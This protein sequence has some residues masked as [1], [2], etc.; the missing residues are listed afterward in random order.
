MECENEFCDGDY[1][2][3]DSGQLGSKF[4]CKEVGEFIEWEDIIKAI[5]EQMEMEQFF[6]S[7]WYIND[8]GNVEE[9]NIFK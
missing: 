1:V 5:K 2:I 4:Y 6:P 9:I 8:H 3:S 7:V